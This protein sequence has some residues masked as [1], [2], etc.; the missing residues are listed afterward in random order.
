MSGLP[1]DQTAVPYDPDPSACMRALDA[2]R[3]TA[4]VAF[5]H[6]RVKVGIRVSNGSIFGAVRGSLP[7][8]IEPVTSPD[9][10][11]LYSV[12]EEPNGSGA[13]PAYTVYSD[14]VPIVRTTNLERAI[15]TLTGDLERLAVEAGQGRLIVRAGA[16]G[17][18]GKGILILGPRSS[19]RSTLVA[20]LLWAGAQ[21]YGDELTVLDPQGRIHPFV[22]PL[23]LKCGPGAEP[24]HLADLGATAGDDPLPIGAMIATAYRPG[25]TWVPR[26]LKLAEAAAMLTASAVT[27]KRQ[28][29]TVRPAFEKM[30]RGVRKF[31]GDRG[32]AG[33]VIFRILSG[34]ST[35]FAGSPE[36]PA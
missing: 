4:G 7:P 27:G 16:V 18:E 2:L 17:W 1:P 25:T 8:G 23:S 11:F 32:E 33:E 12:T 15:N 30:L 31:L 19:G 24:V 10:D 34:F 9:V 3:W 14:V 35:V 29:D 5:T 13:A 26:G 22:R 6:A 21:Y 36:P 20:G 28:P